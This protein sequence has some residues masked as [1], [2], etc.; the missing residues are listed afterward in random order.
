[1]HRIEGGPG[2]VATVLGN[3]CNPPNILRR[4]AL[5]R[6]TDVEIAQVVV[7]EPRE[8]L[9][10]VITNQPWFGYHRRVAA[11]LV[12]VTEGLG[13]VDGRPLAYMHGDLWVHHVA[14]GIVVP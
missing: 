11:L 10:Q 3:L 1:M 6:L 5:I 13:A 4:D 7:G 2:D 9:C 12:H 8:L 14:V